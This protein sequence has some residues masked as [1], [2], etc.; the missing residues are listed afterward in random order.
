MNNIFPNSTL[1]ATQRNSV[2]R[3]VTLPPNAYSSR[4]RFWRK[5]YVNAWVSSSGYHFLTPEDQ[6]L[7]YP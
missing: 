2:V 6:S 7:I 1:S 3:P 5:I 4:D